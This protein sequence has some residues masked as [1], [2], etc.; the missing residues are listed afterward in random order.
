MPSW[1]IFAEQ[2]Q[3]YRDEVLPPGVKARL[4]VEAG[5]TLGWERYVGD[6]GKI[7]GPGPLWG[8]GPRRG[9]V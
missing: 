1:D 2:D 5:A 9:G 6:S 3:A 8:L 7:I 4:A